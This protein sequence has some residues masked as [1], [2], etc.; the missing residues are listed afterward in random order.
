MLDFLLRIFKRKKKLEEE[1][2]KP[3]DFLM[4]REEK[5]EQYVKSLVEREESQVL[6]EAQDFVL[7]I[8]E[9]LSNFKKKF[10]QS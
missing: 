1:K 4:L 2:K 10:N 6:K 7:E 5:I 3:K 8:S 9:K